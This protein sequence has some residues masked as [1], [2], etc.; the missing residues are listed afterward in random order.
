MELVSLLVLILILALVYWGFHQI[1]SSFGLPA[2]IVTVVDILI[3][4]IAVLYILKILGLW[5]GHL[6]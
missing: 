4:V 2:Q 3:V 1:A 5:S 6:G